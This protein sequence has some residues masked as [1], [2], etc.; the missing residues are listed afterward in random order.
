MKFW[1]IE[2]QKQRYSKMAVD[3]L[4]NIKQIILSEVA[5]ITAAKKKCSI[6]HRTSDINAAGD[7]VEICVRSLLRRKLGHNF[8]VGHGHVIDVEW[9]A[10]PQ[11]DV[12][13]TDASVVPSVFR[14]QNGTEFF[15]YESVYAVGEVKATYLKNKKPISCFVKNL[16]KLS[17]LK[18]EDVPANYIRAHSGGFYL[19]NG[20]V[21]SDRHGKQN[22]IFS[23]MLFAG[24]DDFSIEDNIEIFSKTPVGDLPNVTCILDKGLITYSHFDELSPEGSYKSTSLLL[25]PTRPVRATGRTFAWILYSNGANESQS[26]SWGVLCGMLVEHLMNTTVKPNSPIE[27]LQHLASSPK[28]QFITDP[29]KREKD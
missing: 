9:R 13:V 11:F 10:S 15:P 28:Y 7:E 1:V 3:P 16:R 21:S 19:D 12:V 2:T 5:E 4:L 14:S 22:N 20:I 25:H 23:F 8:Y 18:R 26:L 27:Y 24:S 6:L 17:K 29:E